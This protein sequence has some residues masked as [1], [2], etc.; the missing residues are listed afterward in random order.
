[1]ATFGNFKNG[2]ICCSRGWENFRMFDSINVTKTIIKITNVIIFLPM[3]NITKIITRL[4]KLLVLSTT[5]KSTNPV[6]N[7][8]IPNPPIPR[9]PIPSQ[10]LCWAAS[11]LIPTDPIRSSATDQLLRLLLK[12]KCNSRWRK[13]TT[14]KRMLHAAR[15]FWNH[16]RIFS[17]SEIPWTTSQMQLQTRVGENCSR[18]NSFFGLSAAFKTR[19]SRKRPTPTQLDIY[20]NIQQLPPVG[21]EDNGCS[22][23]FGG[24]GQCVQLTNLTPNQLGQVSKKFVF[25]IWWSS[26]EK[27]Y[28]HSHTLL[29]FWWH[30]WACCWWPTTASA[31]GTLPMRP[32][33]QACVAGLRPAQ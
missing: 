12:C 21:C 14:I 13:K 15:W 30:W 17:H 8:P 31:P 16:H 4:W 28:R 11:L 32:P 29:W 1:M 2:W 27:S 20:N 9:N 6:S 23:A 24:A 19:V 7:V 25:F 10:L 33:C 18:L 26:M 22:R 3:P 5:C